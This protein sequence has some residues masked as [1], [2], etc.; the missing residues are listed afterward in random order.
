MEMSW[1]LVIS[2]QPDVLQAEHP[3]MLVAVVP[4]PEVKDGAGLS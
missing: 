2:L 3:I 1:E 4:E